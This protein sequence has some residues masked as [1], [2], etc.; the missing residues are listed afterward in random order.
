LPPIASTEGADP[1]ENSENAALAP[2]GGQRRCS[3]AAA[4]RPNWPGFAFAV[5]APDVVRK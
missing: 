4:D 5:A 2:L 3:P 1:W